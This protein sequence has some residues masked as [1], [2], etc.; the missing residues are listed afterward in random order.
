[1]KKILGM[2]GVLALL[3]AAGAA[4]F[5]WSGL[6]DVSA[7]DQ[8]LA[9][10]YYML[11]KTME[12]S[13]ER[14]ARDIEVPALGA[15][16]QVRRGVALFREHCVQCHGGPGVAPEPFAMGLTPLATPLQR[17][18]LDRSPAYLYWI[19]RNGLKMTGMPA[20]KFRLDD[21]DLW[22]L[23]AFV[24]E[25]PRLTPAEY[26]AL[27]GLELDRS[28][29]RADRAPDPKRGKEALEQYACISCHEIPG[30][31]GPEARLGPPLEGMGSRLMLGGV[32]PNTPENMAR[33]LMAPSAYAHVTA[34]PSMGLTHRDARDMAAY[35]A[36]LK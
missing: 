24:L 26:A 23:V 9:L 35:L 10:T 5:V 30:L 11:Q 32:L 33:W 21:T 3:G 29:D 8:H 34:M 1:M 27:E 13:V 18:G 31:V 14:R 36:T 17:S 19:I 25:L 22:A 28:E 2:L 12:K 15:P 16:A 6:Y 7:T 4:G 20:W